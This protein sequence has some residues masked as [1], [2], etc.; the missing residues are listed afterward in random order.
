MTWIEQTERCID[1]SEEVTL[2]TNGRLAS[3]STNAREAIGVWRDGVLFVTACP[4]Q[5]DDEPFACNAFIAFPNEGRVI[6][7]TSAMLY[8][9]QPLKRLWITYVN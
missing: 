2:Y 9:A 6:K 8:Y 3:A 7:P 5:P 1:C 4:S